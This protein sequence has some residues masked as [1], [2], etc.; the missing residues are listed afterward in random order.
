MVVR[1]GVADDNLLVREALC[2]LLERAPGIELLAVTED[3]SALRAAVD[4]HDLDVVITDIRMPPRGHDEG[5]LLAA[6]LRA[7]RPEVAVVV[8]SAYCEAEYA[9]RLLQSGS[10]GRAY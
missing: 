4:E 6:E 5:I 10:D 3:G 9:L 8:L 7:E 2:R 1:V